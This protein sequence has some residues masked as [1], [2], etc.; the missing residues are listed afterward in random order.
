MHNMFEM[1]Q[2]QQGSI[3]EPLLEIRAHTLQHRGQASNVAH[4]K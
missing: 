4:K 3:A 1:L 2:M